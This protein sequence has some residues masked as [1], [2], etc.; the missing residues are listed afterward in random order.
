MT[1]LH[2]DPP[3]RPAADGGPPP[4]PGRRSRLIALALALLAIPLARSPPR[5]A[6]YGRMVL[7][8]LGYMVSIQL[9]LLGTE[10]IAQGKLPASLGLWWLTIPALLLGVW[11]YSRDGHLPRRRRAR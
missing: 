1:A 2:G 10:L 4:P 9:M 3:S 5:Q 7:D 11:F 8:F 6:R